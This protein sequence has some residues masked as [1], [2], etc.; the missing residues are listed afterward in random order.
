MRIIGGHDYYDG[1]VPFDTDKSR[2]FLRDSKELELP[3]AERF[4]FKIKE[5]KNVDWA[6]ILDCIE[7]IFCG[8][9]Y[10]GI[11]LIQTYSLGVTYR[12]NTITC[13]HP[14]QIRNFVIFDKKPKFTYEPDWRCVYEETLENY[15]TPNPVDEKTFKFLLEHRVMVAI[16][17]FN[18]FDNDK[19]IWVVNSD[20]LKDL[21]FGSVLPTWDAYQELEMFL[22]T[23]LVGD[24][25]RMVKVSDTT[26]LKKYGF[27][28]MSFKNPVHR[29]KPRGKK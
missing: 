11:R 10:R 17:Q 3:P 14:H 24:E 29:N 12:V 7:V 21:N 15:F 22:G 18:A 6:H 20:G 13:W 23:I 26:K 2:V 27:D 4:V 16:R 5:Y 28:G 9:R 1:A 8:K 19:Q 25:D